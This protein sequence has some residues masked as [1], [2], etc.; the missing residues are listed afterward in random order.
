MTMKHKV[1]ATIFGLAALITASAA[2]ASPQTYTLKATPE[3]VV[4]GNYSAAAKPVLRIHSSVCG[5]FQT[6]CLTNSLDRARSEWAVPPD[7]GRKICPYVFDHA[8]AK[9]GDA[10]LCHGLLLSEARLLTP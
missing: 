5:I 1:D 6:R 7:P 9:R 4:W 2:S 3:T 8:A 10:L